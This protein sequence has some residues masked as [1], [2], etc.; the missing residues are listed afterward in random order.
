MSLDLLLQKITS[1]PFRK[2]FHLYGNDRKNAIEYGEIK[3]KTHAMDLISK[4]LAP[5]FPY[6]D[7]KQT[8]YKGHPVF[9]AQHATGTCCRSCL[10]KNHRL[11]KGKQLTETEIE[12]VTSVI[13]RWIQLDIVKYKQIRTE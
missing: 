1:Q 2:K 10:Q 8:P 7:G 9:V 11:P 12:Y 13:Y 3:L 6:K 4:R 5:A